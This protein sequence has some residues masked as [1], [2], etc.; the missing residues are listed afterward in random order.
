MYGSKDDLANNLRNL[1]TDFGR[2]REGSSF[3]YSK[4]FLPL[5]DGF[6]VDCRRDPTESNIGCFLTGDVRANEQVGLLAM[7]VVWFREHNRVAEDLR[8]LNPHWEG[9]RIYHEARKVM[10]FG[11]T[12]KWATVR[13]YIRNTRAYLNLTH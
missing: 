2:L 3:G 1:S 11:D 10:P 12:S 7:H 8:K 13:L 6:P 9:D 5:N 4:P